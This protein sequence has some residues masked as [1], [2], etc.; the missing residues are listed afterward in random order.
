MST[1][2]TARSNGFTPAAPA[3]WAALLTS[4]YLPGFALCTHFTDMA[5]PPPAPRRTLGATLP[6]GARGRIV[7]RTQADATVWDGFPEV[8]LL[9]GGPRGARRLAHRL[10]AGW[11]ADAD[12]LDTLLT[13]GCRSGPGIS[14][15]NAGDATASPVGDQFRVAVSRAGLAG[16]AG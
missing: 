3:A 8:S 7:E 10:G 11:A 1:A 13:D 4:G 9:C 15:R 6:L 16:S 14:D 12:Q 5:E 2:R